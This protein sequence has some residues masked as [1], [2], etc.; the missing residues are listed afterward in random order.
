MSKKERLQELKDSLRFEKIVVSRSKKFKG[1]DFFVSYS[2][3]ENLE[4]ESPG[5]SGEPQKK[6]SFTDLKLTT[7]LM[8]LEAEKAV[9]TAA[10]TASDITQEEYQM[11]VKNLQS[12]F[13]QMI[14][15]ILN[16]EESDA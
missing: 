5:D 14:T 3:A 15:Y 2:L 6:N 4:E 11:A 1:G 10:Y 12:N 13:S 9:Y 7:L 16:K 8:Q